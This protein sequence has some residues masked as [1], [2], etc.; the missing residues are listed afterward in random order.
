MCVL[1]NFAK[2]FI[3]YIK[4]QA[5]KRSAA[6]KDGRIM[7]KMK[8]AVVGYGGMGGWH[9]EKLLKSDVAELAGIYD[10]RRERNELAESRGI[11]AY[12]S[13]RE[14]LQDS[15]VELVTVA[16]P[17]DAHED[18]VVKALNAGKNV[19]CE[20]PVALSLESLNRMIEAAEKNHVHFS[21]HQNRRWDV[22]YL[23]MKQVHDS[24]ELGKVINI[25]S[26]IHGSRGIPSDW[27]GEK[28]HG[29]GMLYDWG[30]HLIDQMLMIF[31]FE[32]V[33]SVYCICDHITNQEV[34]DGFRLDLNFKNGQRATVEVGTYNFIA[35]PRFYMRAEKGSALITD[36]REEAQ[37]VKCTHWHES[38]VLPVET[39]AGLT[40]TMAPRDGITTD[41]YRV[42]KPQSDV[43]DYYRNFIA[44]IRGEA[45]QC[46]TYDQMRTDLR[47][48]LAAFESAKEGKVVKL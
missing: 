38:E 24:G 39:A 26:R 1:K 40:K 42:P 45:T 46:V 37:V 10:I 13:L 3:L 48:I 19:I 41:T 27:R 43:H 47:V 17:N 22:D 15:E 35:M 18:V 9:T 32:N 44:T 20:K 21:T 5:G 7:K 28:V 33:E 8:V 29:G 36:W 4:K 34:D 25:E 6:K 12:G 16:V 2:R 14:L 30:I 11:H 31:G 23:A